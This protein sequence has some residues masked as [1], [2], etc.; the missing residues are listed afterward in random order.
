[1]KK[2]AVILASL[3]VAACASTHK[4]DTSSAQAGE[5]NVPVL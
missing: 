1:M 2:I 3:L 5:K 4:T